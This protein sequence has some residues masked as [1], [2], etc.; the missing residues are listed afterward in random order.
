M[1]TVQ[2][3]SDKVWIKKKEMKTSFRS[4]NQEMGQETQMDLSPVVEKLAMKEKSSPSQKLSLAILALYSS[5]G[6]FQV[7][8]KYIS[9]QTS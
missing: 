2:S 5:N 1:Q 7:V 3:E 4:L 9:A 6:H 8:S